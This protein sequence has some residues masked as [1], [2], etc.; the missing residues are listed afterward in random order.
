M[1]EPS[2]SVLNESPRMSFWEQELAA[3][4]AAAISI[5]QREAEAE[6]RFDETLA[7]LES[8]GQA[9]AATES[10]EFKEWMAARSQTDEAW[11]RWAQV[12]DSRPA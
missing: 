8:R 4:E 10:P 6:R 7:V 3:V 12:M 1:R 2:Y 9:E 5:E 11:G